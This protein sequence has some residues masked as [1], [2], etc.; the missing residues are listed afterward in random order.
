MK[1]E[2]VK[3]NED[4][5]EDYRNWRRATLADN[6]YVF[7]VD[8]VEYR[9]RNGSPEPVAVI[10][11]TRS[12]YKSANPDNLLAAVLARITEKSAQGKALVT[13]ADALGVGAYI[14][15]FEKDL[16]AFY[17][18]SLTKPNGWYIC[19]QEKYVRFLNWLHEKGGR[20]D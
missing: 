9:F 16:S 20:N 19:D 5:T 8:Q 10:E 13:V 18:Y 17:V 4:R 12:D 15:V 11:L 1:K 14:V 2:R 3:G 7:D 6:R